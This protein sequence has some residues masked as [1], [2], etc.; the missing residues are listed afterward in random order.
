MSIIA[1]L[2]AQR[3]RNIHREYRNQSI[4]NALTWVTRSALIA[5]GVWCYMNRAHLQYVLIDLLKH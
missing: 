3:A 5:L 1:Q 4:R 2:N